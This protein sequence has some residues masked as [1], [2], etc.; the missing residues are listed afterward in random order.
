[1]IL[2]FDI[3][4][5]HTHLGLAN[6]HRVIKQADVPTQA[7]FNGTAQK[8]IGKFAARCAVD[9][10]AVCSVVPRATPH[11]KR[12]AAH[13]WRVKTFE[14]THRTL[15]GVGI[16][17][18]KPA[19]IGPDRL[20][21]AVAARHHYGAPS[22][23]VDFGTA[24]TF[25]VVDKRGNYAGGIIAPGLAAMTDYLH[26][27]TALLPRIRIAEPT[28]IIGKN[29]KQAMLVGA[30]HGYRG[31]IRELITELKE[32]LAAKRLPVIA[33]G[34]YAKLIGRKLREITAIDPLLTLEGLRLVW[35]ANQTTN[36]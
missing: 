13:L 23:V 7:W 34:G 9:G 32:E 30:V 12:I 11:A 16:N 31:L 18:P 24:V 17:Y 2:L 20:A 6:S 35:C 21:N 10:A 33:T 27:K 5:T 28:A 19:S 15:R 29:T 22:L 1:M 26:E 3:G 25:D 14:L 4:N 8:L 36:P